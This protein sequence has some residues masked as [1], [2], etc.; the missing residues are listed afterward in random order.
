MIH[1]G[2]QVHL[3]LDLCSLSNSWCLIFST[4]AYQHSNSKQVNFP[5]SIRLS[6]FLAYFSAKYGYQNLSANLEIILMKV[7]RWPSLVF[8]CVGG[9][10]C[11]LVLVVASFALLLVVPATAALVLSSISAAVIQARSSSVLLA[12]K[13]SPPVTIL[14]LSSGRPRER[15]EYYLCV[16]GITS[17]GGT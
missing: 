10:C 1:Y 6:F 14:K 12:S 7:V 3:L 2:K 9:D 5:T 4:F 17:T 16:L 15:S 13:S 8:F 11:S